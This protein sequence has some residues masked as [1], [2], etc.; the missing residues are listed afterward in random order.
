MYH[1]VIS[2][3]SSFIQHRTF[4]SLIR[5]LKNDVP[6]LFGFGHCEVFLHDHLG[7][8][9][10]CM[11]VSSEEEIRDSEEDPPG[12]EEEFIISE[13]RIVRFPAN[14]GI[15]GY[16]L[17]GDAVCYVNDFEHKIGD[18]VAPLIGQTSTSRH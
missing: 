14:M 12:F 8:N 2:F 18:G 7:K 4:R 13:Q 6:K 1:R 17:R 5:H 15:S 10:Y 9:L 11:S 3:A 16:A